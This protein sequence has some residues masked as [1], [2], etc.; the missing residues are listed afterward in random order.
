VASISVVPVGLTKWREG[1][2]PLEPFTPDDAANVLEQVGQWQNKFFEEHGTR[3]VFPADE[4][5]IKAGAELPAYEEYE[6]FLQIE[7]G[8]GLLTQF[9]HEFREYLDT[10]GGML[11]RLWKGRLPR[12][13]SIAT[14]KCAAGYIGQLAKTLERRYNGL[15]INVYAI[16]NEFFGENVTVTGL[17]TGRD[18]A[19]QLKGR[20]MGS[21]LLISRSMLKSDEELFLDDYTIDGLSL[22]LGK[23]VTVVDNDGAD[24]INRALGTT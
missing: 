15:Q 4:L 8:V 17:L 24:F 10:D 2:Y 16:E 23:K 21:E 6:D 5:Y 12:T 9:L 14:G 3:L 22:A 1:L 7:N 20:P 11:D 13:V 18:I 19:G